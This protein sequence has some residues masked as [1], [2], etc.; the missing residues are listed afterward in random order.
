MSAAPPVLE[1]EDLCVELDGRDGAAPRRLV[2]RVS[3][4]VGPGEV[5]GVVGESGSGKSLT[6]LAIAG[7]LP[8]GVRASGRVRLAGRTLDGLDDAA[9][10]ALRGREF[11]FVF[12][13]PFASLNPVRRVGSL[14][15]ESVLR[16]RAL[17]RT[18]ARVRAIESLRAVGLP[19]PEQ[20]VDHYPHQ[21]SGGQRQRALIALAL[22][23]GPRLLI[24]DEPTTALDPTVRLAILDLLVAGADERGTV[25]VTHDF[26]VAERACTTIAVMYHGRLVEHGPASAVLAAPRHPYTRAL[27][28]AV[29]RFH[30]PPPAAIAGTPP[31][32][33]VPDGCA[34]RARCARAD[35]ACA[36][37][38]EPVA[39]GAV[40]VAC[41]HVGT[42]QMAAAGGQGA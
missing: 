9:L 32:G 13:D 21:L 10:A 8:P 30:G 19:D 2:D 12:Q 37:T 31:S 34:F 15:V 22:V 38:P 6:M 36:A 42:S 25:L 39:H 24:A 18:A 28:D 16:H 33:P 26:G 27:L 35:A 20:R 4:T 14:L 29:P 7:L 17:D 5:L 40:R 23:N 11:G 3:F 1:V 41:H